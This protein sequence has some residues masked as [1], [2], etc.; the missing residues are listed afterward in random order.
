[1]NSERLALE[2][3]SETAAL[4]IEQ[5]L[6]AP[7]VG[8]DRERAGDT[9]ASELDASPVRAPIDPDDSCCRSGPSMGMI[10]IAVLGLQPF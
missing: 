6:S 1:L 2:R 4:E 8:L 10:V 7:K 3:R 5:L 9:N